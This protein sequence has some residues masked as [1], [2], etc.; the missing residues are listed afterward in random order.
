MNFGIILKIQ[1]EKTY[2]NIIFYYCK[3]CRKIYISYT[4]LSFFLQ[5]ILKI[6]FVH[7]FLFTPNKLESFRYLRA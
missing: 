5:F 6:I 1:N 7:I 4:N 3:F 2:F